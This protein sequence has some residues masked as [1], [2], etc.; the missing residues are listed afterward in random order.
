VSISNVI[1]KRIIQYTC[2][3]HVGLKPISCSFINNPRLK[4][5]V[6]E[7]AVTMGLSPIIET[8]YRTTVIKNKKLSLF[9]KNGF[10]CFLVVLKLHSAK[11]E[12]SIEFL[13]F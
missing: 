5:G 7:N 9:N 12:I 8:F 10:L 1:T 6:I 11:N 3:L 13:H 4:S 2:K